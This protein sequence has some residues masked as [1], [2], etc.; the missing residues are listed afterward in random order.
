MSKIYRL[1]QVITTKTPLKKIVKR[2]LYTEEER[3]VSLL[4]A[5]ERIHF[6]RTAEYRRVRMESVMINTV[7][8]HIL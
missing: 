3:Q 7:D 8:K 6:M 1:S 4:R 5:Q 2:V